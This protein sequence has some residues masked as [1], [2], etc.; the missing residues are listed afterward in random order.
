MKVVKL[1]RWHVL[2]IAVGV[3]VAYFAVPFPFLGARG[4][5]NVRESAIRW[6]LHHNDSG[7]Q[8]ELQVCFI[9]TGTSFDPRA[10]DFGPR[11]PSKEFLKRFSNLPVP[12]LPV[13]ANTNRFGVA[14][15][16]GKRGLILAAGNVNRW[17]MGVATCRGLYYEG[18]LS[19]AGYEIFLLHLPFVWVPVCS[20]MLWIS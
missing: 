10:T 16:T 6:L 4:R 19:S 14:D 13:S 9:G 1:K 2:S 11:D 15:A 5:D 3:L 20:R 17:S 8:N 18:G 12:T 7:M